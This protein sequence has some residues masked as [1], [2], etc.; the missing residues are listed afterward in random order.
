[1]SP[2][3]TAL[4]LGGGG[5][6]GI[7]WELGLIAGL[8]EGGVDLSRAQVVIGTSAG[9]V[10][11]AQITSG[12]AVE[13]LYAG[14]LE[15]PDREI[16][17]HFG[18]SSMVRLGVMM[19][20]PGSGR[21]RRRRVG[22]A[23]MRVT[24]VP[25]AERVQ[26]IRSRLG[27]RAWPDRRLLVIAVDAE[28][29]ATTVFDRDS[30]VGLVEA[31]AASCAVPLVWPPVPINGR[32]YVDGGIRSSTNADLATGVD[33]VVV[34]APLPKSFN[35][36]GRIDNQLAKL[37]TEVRSAVVSPDAAAL[38]AIGRNVLDPAQRAAAARAGRR[39][40]ADVLDHVR[41]VWP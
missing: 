22:R 4:V 8:A 11:G 17:A 6:T 13:D 9:S 7:A 31:V 23:A 19:A 2:P 20:L 15:P 14:Q 37:G 33:R 30:G 39:Q 27:T 28:S 16:G 41:T 21:R 34:L 18:L 25:V 29:G 10:V 35:K 32:R 40:A 36:A 1:M 3:S 12:E 38:K 5:I 26:V 24:S